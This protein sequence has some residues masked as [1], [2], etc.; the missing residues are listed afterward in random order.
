M[1]ESDV[2][3][4][5][6]PYDEDLS[7]LLDGELDAGGAAV[8]RNHVEACA[9]CTARVEALRAVDT[10]L[11]AM[12]A[13]VPSPAEAERLARLRARLATQQ[14]Q[15]Q[16]LPQRASEPAEADAEAL[17]PAAS[18]GRGGARSR[19]RRLPAALLAVAAALVAALALPR[20]LDRTLPADE[21]PLA[22]G[23]REAPPA[24]AQ[25]RA[26]AEAPARATRPAPTAAERPAT[27]ATPAARLA[28]RQPLPKDKAFGASA[29]ADDA[30]GPSLA[31]LDEVDLALALDELE[32]VE[33]E[34]LAVVESLDALER[35][36]EAGDGGQG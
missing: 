20:L 13:A 30:G 12:A 24:D 28:A 7:A 11:R 8:V 21:S 18:A 36:A 34:D 27:P 17:A 5:C 35:M 14:S 19:R 1:S 4:R 3:A 32:G 33:P 2:P 16:P 23:S 22:Q 25:P 31:V 6:A 29:V 9:R 10:R 15:L 26:L